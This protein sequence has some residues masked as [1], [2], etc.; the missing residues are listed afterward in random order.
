MTE[1]LFEAQYDVSKKSK[2]RRIYD[3]YKV[4]IYSSII[5]FFILF[6]SFSFYIENKEKKKILLSEKYFQAKIHLKENRKE[7]GYKL[8]QEILFSNDSTYSTLSFF[9]IINESLVVDNQKLLSFFDHL[10]ENNKFSDEIKN[11]LIYKKALMN[12]DYIS[13]SDLLESMKPLLN[14][15]S[16]WK[17]HGLLLLG[18]YFVSKKENVKAIEFYQKIFTI[19]DLHENL[20]NHARSQLIL[21][22]NE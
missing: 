19:K 14:S 3:T 5:I 21:I 22:S 10:L 15:E 6:G 20:Y 8:L 7:E 18:D 11:L 13:E 12:A 17:P 2:L 16:L 4:W 1:N 9:L